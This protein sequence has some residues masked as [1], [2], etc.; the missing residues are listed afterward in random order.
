MK[1]HSGLIALSAC[2]LSGC[3]QTDPNPQGTFW[4]ALQS[5]C[6]KAYSGRLVSRDE[7]DADMRGRAMVMHVAECSDTL[8]EIP[9]HIGD[10]SDGWDRSRTW[11]ITR[12]EAGLRLKHRH[13][14]RDGSLDQVTNYGGDAVDAGASRA[15]DFP[16]DSESIRLFQ[17]TGLEPSVANTWRIEVDGAESDA[18]QPTFVYQ[19]RRPVPQRR[20]FR[21]EFDLS[22]PVDPP[23]P[24]W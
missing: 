24:A 4:S 1:R 20:L 23:P 7:I 16:A 22:K 2:I 19:L 18:E 21:V 14:H 8:I 9:F 3:S 17:Q 11:Q 10:P 6:G 5:H 13:A 12:T 15:Q